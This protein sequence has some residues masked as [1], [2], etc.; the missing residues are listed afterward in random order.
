MQTPLYPIHAAL[1]AKIIDFSGWEMPIQYQSILEEHKA[2]REHAGI[3]DVSHMG[4]I[5]VMG[6]DAELFC[7]FVSTNTIAHKK[8]GQAIYTV[9]C[10]EDGTAID[11]VIILRH[12]PQNCSVVSN[13]SNRE[14]VLSHLQVSAKDF[15]VAINSPYTNEGILAIQGPSSLTIASKLFPETASLAPMTSIK[16][17]GLLISRTGYTGEKG[18]EIFVPFSQLKEIWDLFIQEGVVPVGLGARDTLRLEKG[19]A[20]FG[21]ELS[22]TTQPTETVSAWA[23]KLT[24]ENFIGKQALLKESSGRHQYGIILDEPGIARAGCPV[25]M[26]GNQIG[27][28]TSGTFSP[29][30]K[31]SI[32]I[33]MVH[34]VL[35]A[36]DKIEVNIRDKPCRATVVQLPFYKG[37]SQ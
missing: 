23:V 25:V 31:K 26:Q 33:V 3:F 11:D 5:S 34:H 14:R 20:L 2:V 4:R 17:A 21:H 35:Q 32:A 6:P 30:L 36:G 9:L 28:V 13:A 7:D 8:D 22:D 10:R 12:S 27:E 37:P 29:T 24:K 19:Y 1:G 15:N 16:T 18:I